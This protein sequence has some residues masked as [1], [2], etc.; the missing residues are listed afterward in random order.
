[1]NSD[2][3]LWKRLNGY[4]FVF[5]TLLFLVAITQVIDEK[6]S[7]FVLE[8]YRTLVVVLYLISLSILT[9]DFVLDMI[10]KARKNKVINKHNT[11][12]IN[13]IKNLKAQEKFLLSLF[14]D[15]NVLELPISHQEPSLGLLESK[16]ILVNTYQK[17]A[18]GKTIYRID[19]LILEALKVNPNL[20]F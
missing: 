15:K 8:D 20:L 4:L 7:Q 17:E 18:N 16:K 10:H 13:Q 5:L 19:P 2:K 1:M 12:F 6:I 11:D 14:V 3:K 9:F